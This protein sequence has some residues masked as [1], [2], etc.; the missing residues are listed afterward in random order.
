MRA[1]LQQMIEIPGDHRAA[2]KLRNPADRL[3]E[4]VE[5]VVARLVQRHHDNQNAAGPQLLRIEV[6]FVPDIL[7]PIVK[8]EANQY[9]AKLKFSEVRR[10]KPT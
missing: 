1:D 2:L 4:A 10:V 5:G 6:G 9:F 7:I 8:Q 3:V